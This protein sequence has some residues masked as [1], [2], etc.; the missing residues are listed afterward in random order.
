M[1]EGKKSLRK[2]AKIFANTFAKI[3]VF[4]KIFCF[5]KVFAKIFHSEC[6]SG[7]R[8]HLNM[9]PDPN[10]GGNYLKFSRKQS[11]EQKCFAKTKTS[12]KTKT[13]AKAKF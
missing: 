13:F 10:T 4:A 9:Y 2:V 3:F 7:Y 12:A 1:R 6:G 8:S 5:E 11:R